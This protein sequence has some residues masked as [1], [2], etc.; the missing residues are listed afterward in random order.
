MVF[1]GVF[2]FILSSLQVNPTVGSIGS[3]HRSS[4]VFTQQ[5]SIF[6]SLN[7]SFWLE[8]SLE[9]IP[10]SI[11]DTNLVISISWDAFHSISNPKND[12]PHL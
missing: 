10:N 12:M 4:F 3:F 5:K 6:K 7:I 8:K 1:F 2:H 11:V 9:V